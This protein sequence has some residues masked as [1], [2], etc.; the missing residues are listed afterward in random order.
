M[1]RKFRQFSLVAIFMASIP[2]LNAQAGPPATQ[3]AGD[4]KIAIDNFA[5][6]PAE[7]TVPAGTKVTW[8][9]H[10]DVPHTATSSD[11][12][13][14]FDSG[15]IDTDGTFSFVFKKPGNYPYFC[16]VHPHMTGRIIVK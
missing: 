6:S 14:A 15:A 9:N 2:F 7:I 16:E 10:D 11:K 8:V 5:F 4:Q 1:S 13:G 12:P 3:A